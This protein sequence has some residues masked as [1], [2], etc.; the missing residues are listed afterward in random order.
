MQL[1]SYN[2]S[3]DKV[4]E[5]RQG[6]EK[7]QIE[8]FSSKQNQISLKQQEI[9]TL[10]D[11]YNA[12]KKKTSS[13]KSIEDMTREQLYR[14]NLADKISREEKTLEDLSKELELS[15][16]ELVNAQKD[17]KIMEKLKEK[18]YSKFQSRLKSIEQNDLDEI[19]TLKFA[20]S[21]L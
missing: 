7:K 12:V 6:V 15:R 16:Q 13:Y 3:M 18:D 19:N 2:F 14:Q 10:T 11:E 4:L 17:R 21:S 20:R 1:R 9:K 8:K 5:Y